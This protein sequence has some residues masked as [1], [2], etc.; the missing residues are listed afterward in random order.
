[1]E[2][3]FYTDNFEQLLRE[4]TDE[5]R[6][7]PSKRVWHSLYNDLHPG[8]KW[9]S[10][11]VL[12]L[13]ITSIMYIGV[14]NTNEGDGSNDNLYTHSRS[15]NPALSNKPNS[16]KT[17]ALLAAKNVLAVDDKTGI[18]AVSPANPGNA[19]D[20]SFAD[21][22]RPYSERPSIG[23]LPGKRNTR[24]GTNSNSTAPDVLTQKAFSQNSIENIFATSAMAKI[25]VTDGALAI[26]ETVS[27]ET[28]AVAEQEDLFSNTVAMKAITPTPVVTLVKEAPHKNNIDKITPEQRAWM[29]DFAF[30]NKKPG[31]K[32]KNRVAYQF[33]VTP[34]VGYRSFEKNTNY[35][36][37]AAAS[38]ITD[39]QARAMDNSLNHSEALNLEAGGNILFNF[40]KRIRLK[41]GLQLNYTNYHIDAY[42]LNHP[43]STTLM[44][45]DI[46]GFPVL[47]ARQ[48][49]LANTPGLSSKNLNNNSYQLSIP[50]GAEVRLA[51]KNKLKWYAGATVQP[52]YVA[53]GNSYLIS[54]DLKNYVVG[55]EFRRKFNLNGGFETYVSYKLKNGLI[56]NAGPQFR[57]QFLS[58]YSKQYSYDEK[59]YNLGIKLGVTTNF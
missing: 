52:T 36:S 7:Y 19:F 3:K 26:T 9:P 2:N 25:T 42:Q 12:L 48:T 6:M 5:F 21:N 15:A 45:N 4:T 10:G 47:E 8:R 49:S 32:W 55:N 11:A 33:Y 24:A 30:H 31:R 13:L 46:G 18:A 51:G 23:T 35:S 34:A 50:L 29:E 44:L 59:L 39:P 14:S 53:A 37:P 22:I 43:S 41:A 28:F 1:M 58:T 40:S 38:L 56:L 17:A 16:S 27:T 54:S 20:L 57:Y